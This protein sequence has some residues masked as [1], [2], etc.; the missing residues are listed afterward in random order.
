MAHPKKPS[1]SEVLKKVNLLRRQ[2]K[3]RL[4]HHWK[5][6]AK[7]R[8][9]DL[10]DFRSV[11]TTGRVAEEGK[12]DEKYGNWK[13]RIDGYDVEGRPFSVVIALEKDT[14]VLIT[15]VRKRGKKWQA[16]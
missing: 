16:E 7:E 6:R 4:T 8:G 12:W 15:G 5:V 2:G 14:L 10:D 11:C 3:V 1:R 9:F 13:Y